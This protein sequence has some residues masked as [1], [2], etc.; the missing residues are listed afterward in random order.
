MTQPTT[1]AEV[2][3]LLDRRLGHAARDDIWS[4]LIRREWV[5]GVL[6]DRG[7]M[8]E[9]VDEYRAVER[10]FPAGRRRMSATP[11]PPREPQ[12]VEPDERL[13][14]LSR[15]LARLAAEE[16][17][18][19]AFRAEVLGGQLLA[20]EDVAAWVKSQAE[21]DG[22][23]TLYLGDVAV[24]PGHTVERGREAGR[25]RVWVT[26][27]LTLSKE[28]PARSAGGGFLVY[29]VPGQRA[30]FR[31]PVAHGGTLDR[32]RRL[33]ERLAGSYGWEG[34]TGK[35]Q[36]ALF[37]LTG[38]P[39]LIPR[40]TITWHIDLGSPVEG[41]I[42]LDLDPTLGPA[43]VAKLYWQAREQFPLRRRSHRYRPMTEKHARLAEWADKEGSWRERM[44]GWNRACPEDHAD[45]HYSDPRNFARDVTHAARRLYGEEAEQ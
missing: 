31:V 34:D 32:L 24:P 17:A 6:S 5:D 8:K 27:P 12:Y 7:L 1:E 40:A 3:K 41:R 18:I 4:D 20:P 16:P 36:A 25:L 45:W 35:A 38:Q 10:A 29:A 14:A 11:S 19:V 44:E 15:R 26:P 21:A 37:V 42:T 22:E 39:P 28:T 13:K 43:A 33:S 23:S 9:L 30:V 2:R